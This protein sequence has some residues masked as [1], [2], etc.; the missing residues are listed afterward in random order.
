MW[1]LHAVVSS[2][3]LYFNYII[4]RIKYIECIPCFFHIVIILIP[5]KIL[6][7]HDLNNLIFLCD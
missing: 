5:L 2:G 7:E 4:G 6:Q 3:I 1:M